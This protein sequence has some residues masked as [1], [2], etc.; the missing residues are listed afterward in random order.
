MIGGV[1]DEQKA[2]VG[3]PWVKGKVVYLRCSHNFSF[4]I[5][6]T[7]TFV[8][9]QEKKMTTPLFKTKEFLMEMK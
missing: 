1:G 9:D 7:D 4:R 5:D 3:I 2:V 6:Q 8:V